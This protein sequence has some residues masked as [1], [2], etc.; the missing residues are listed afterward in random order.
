MKNAALEKAIAKFPT[1]N[2]FAE[3]VGVESYKTVQQWRKNGVPARHCAKVE[4][5]TGVKRKQLRPKDW[6]KYWPEL[7][8]A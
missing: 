4:S 7:A 2:A 8:D 3:A 1:L 6:Q 5:L